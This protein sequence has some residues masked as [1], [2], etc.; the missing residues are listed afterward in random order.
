MR[1]P[2]NPFDKDLGEVLDEND[3]QRL[4]TKEVSE[5]FFIEYKSDFPDKAKI[6]KS[7]AAFANTYGGWLFIGVKADK[8]NNTAQAISGFDSSRYPDPISLVRNT[9]KDWLNPTPVIFPQVIHLSSG[10]NA[11]AIRIPGEQDLPFIHKDG[12][13]YRRVGDSSDP[14]FEADRATLD[15]LISKRDEQIQRLEDFCCDERI[16]SKNQSVGWLSFFLAPYPD[17]IEKSLNFTGSQ[18]EEILNKSKNSIDL[19]LPK[20]ISKTEKITL[21]IPINSI[22]LTPESYILGQT[23]EPLNIFRNFSMELF[24]NFRAKI[25]V[26]IS[27]IDKSNLMAK[28]QSEECLKIFDRLTNRQVENIIQFVD[29]FKTI[30]ALSGLV[31]L[32]LDIIQEKYPYF[33]SIRIFFKPQNIQNR[34]VFFD[35]DAWASHVKTFGIPI[36]EHATFSISPKQDNYYQ[37]SIEDKSNI[38]LI[39]QQMAGLALG[40][41]LYL[42]REGFAHG[43]INNWKEQGLVT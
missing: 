10:R 39:C 21:G 26:P 31:S 37:P 24:F 1:T 17:E 2:F 7:L 6:A 25:H 27:H 12:R 23:Q 14:I 5:G 15:R 3:L 32:Y 38:V 11:L 29:L 41:P 40:V 19:F 35:S 34:I 16:T 20:E 42:M 18:L 4:V 13:I 8:I 30:A 22:A 28:I 9:A 43:L 36:T 33:S